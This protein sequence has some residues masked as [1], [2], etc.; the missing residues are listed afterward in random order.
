[1][2][3]ENKWTADPYVDELRKELAAANAKI[4]ALVDAGDELLYWVKEVALNGK[5][6]KAWTAAKEGAK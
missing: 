1:M 4:K 5:E 6:V 2:S 3:E